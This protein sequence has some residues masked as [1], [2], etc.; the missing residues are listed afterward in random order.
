MKLVHAHI[1]LGIIVKSCVGKSGIFIFAKLER[2]SVFLPFN[3]V[4]IK[5]VSNIFALCTTGI[6]LLNKSNVDK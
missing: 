2:K 4:T 1:Y 6:S 3:E 5:L